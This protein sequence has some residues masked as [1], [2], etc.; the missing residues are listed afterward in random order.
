MSKG[1]A[2]LSVLTDRPS[3]QGAPEFLSLARAASCLPVLRKDFLFDPYQVYEARNWGADCILIILAAIDDSL[4]Q[5]LE[6]TALELGMDVL[7]ET[8]DET[9]KM[10][11]ALKLRSP[12]IGLNNRNLRDFTV[13]LANSERLARMVP[14]GKLLVAE[15]AISTRGDCQRLQKSGIGCFLIGESLMQPGRCCNSNQNIAKTL[16]DRAFL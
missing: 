4:A 15:S 12:L 16:K 11:R 8:H 6:E 14:S 9:E 7:L 13:D 2:C 1:A 10:E 3:F 5:A